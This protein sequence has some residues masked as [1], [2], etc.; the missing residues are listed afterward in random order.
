MLGAPLHPY[1][2]ALASS[3]PGNTV[4]GARLESIPGR[5]PVLTA[6]ASGCAF[7][8]RCSFAVDRCRNERPAPTRIDGRTVLCHRAAEVGANA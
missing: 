2:A 7:A 6:A 8:D 5:P 4:R 3:V 1:T